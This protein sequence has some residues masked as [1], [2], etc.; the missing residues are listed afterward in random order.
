MQVRGFSAWLRSRRSSVTESVIPET[1]P[2]QQVSEDVT[3][4]TLVT[5]TDGSESEH[6]F[7]RRR[8]RSQRR[9]HQ[10]PVPRLQTIATIR[11][12]ASVRRNVIESGKQRWRVRVDEARRRIAPRGS[13]ATTPARPEFELIA[14]IIQSSAKLPGA[15]CTDHPGMFDGDNPGPRRRGHRPVPPLPRPERVPA[16]R[17]RTERAPPPPF[18]TASGPGN[19]S[20]AR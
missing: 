20:A 9:L 8:R 11:R 15:L 2:D 13:T 4:V 16:S 17:R 7:Q 6:R 3:P 12:T 5:F 14:A 19:A 18:R 1:C 10:R